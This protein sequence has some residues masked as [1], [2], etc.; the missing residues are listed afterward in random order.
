MKSWALWVNSKNIRGH[1]LRF[2]LSVYI[3][4]TIYPMLSP[5]LALPIDTAYLAGILESN[6][7]LRYRIDSGKL[8]GVYRSR[9]VKALYIV[10]KSFGGIVQRPKIK[11]ST[12]VLTLNVSQCWLIAKS[13]TA[14][15]TPYAPIYRTII[16]L[17]EHKA[18]ADKVR[19]STEENYRQD[20]NQELN[21]LITIL[22]EAQPNDE[23]NQPDSYKEGIAFASLSDGLEADS[24]PIVWSKPKGAIE[25]EDRR[26]KAENLRA[27]MERKEAAIRSRDAARLKRQEERKSRIAEERKQREAVWKA[28][29]E[30][31]AV[32]KQA[33]MQAKAEKRA[34]LEVEDNDSLSRGVCKCRKC[35]EIKPVDQFAVA[36]HIKRGRALNCKEC[37]YHLYTVPNRVRNLERCKRWQRDNKDKFRAS[38]QK[39]NRKPSNR[40]RKSV[41]TRIKAWLGTYLDTHKHVAY[42]G[43][44]LGDLKSYIES[45]W[46][47]GM[48]WDNYGKGENQWVIDHIVPCAAFDWSIESHLYWCWNYRNLRPLWASENAAKSDLIEG[49]SMRQY[50]TSGQENEAR[51][52]VDRQLSLMGILNPGDFLRSF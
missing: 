17:Q 48:S 6:L 29:R 45:L 8:T 46:Q 47:P 7:S 13:L 33:A 37:V 9:C 31:R 42:V 35:L 39:Q 23:T 50:K 34:A 16:A 52:I 51:K 24:L 20:Y 32:A 11:A 3:G 25:E 14:F 28:N 26:R 18:A 1:F 4:V 40:L 30:K 5:D 19:L 36:R 12:L 15:N 49:I 2:P 27:K 43:A 38:M 22:N 41:R 44:T 21:R 10:Q